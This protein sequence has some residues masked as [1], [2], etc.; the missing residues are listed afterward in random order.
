MFGKFGREG[1]EFAG[2]NADKPDELVLVGKGRLA[3]SLSKDAFLS[4]L[5]KESVLTVEAAEKIIGKENLWGNDDT[6][7]AFGFEGSINT[8]PLVPFS[9]EDLARFKEKKFILQPVIDKTPDGEP[10]TMEKMAEL[11]GSNKEIVTKGI[12]RKQEEVWRLYKD[13]FGENGEMLGGAWFSGAQY[14]AMRAE[15]PKAG[16]QVVSRGTINGTKSL[17]YIPQTEKLIAYAKETFG[18]TL[19]PAYAE[20]EQ[21]FIREKPSIEALI[22]DS[23]WVEASQKLSELSISQLLREPYANTIFRYVVGTKSRNERLLTDEYTWSS[24]PSGVGSLV[25][26]GGAGA[27]GAR[28]HGSG[29]G[30]DWTLVGAVFSRI[31]S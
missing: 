15:T 29:P 16:W 27:E 24:T 6:Q 17:S 13:Q 31:E 8:L 19:P 2:V 1:V 23:K 7:K 22:Q 10:L 26:F 21:Q 3:R 18:G 11:V 12:T 25:G 9:K 4:E 20:A 14:A 5:A 28:V 30:L